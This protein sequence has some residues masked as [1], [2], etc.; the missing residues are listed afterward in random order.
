M[1]KQLWKEKKVISRIFFIFILVF[2]VD[3]S[4]CSRKNLFVVL[5]PGFL[6]F[7]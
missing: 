5:L 1:L 6:A 3:H 4:V 7:K 2:A